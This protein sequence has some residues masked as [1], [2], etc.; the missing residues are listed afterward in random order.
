MGLTSSISL[1][2]LVVYV[3]Y[4][5]SMVWEMCSPHACRGVQCYRPL[6]SDERIDLRM[7]VAG[8]EVWQSL[9]LSA[10][11]QLD[12]QVE[13]PVPPEVRLGAVDNLTVEVFL[14]LHGATQPIVVARTNAVKRMLPRVHEA[15]MLLDDITAS[16][17]SSE[18]AGKKDVA[19]AAPD[20]QGKV[21]HYIFARSRMDVRLVR[22]RTPHASVY[23]KDGVPVGSGFDHAQRRFAPHFY[24]DSFPLLSK[25]ALPLSSDVQRKHPALRVRVTPIS[26]GWHRF[27]SQMNTVLGLLQVSGGG[28]V[29]LRRCT[30]LRWPAAGAPRLRPKTSD[31]RRGRHRHSGP[32]RGGPA[33]AGGQRGALRRRRLRRDP[34][35][36]LGGAH[37]PLPADAGD[38]AACRPPTPHAH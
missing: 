6:L 11:E 33:A 23:F 5:T 4:M 27:I 19:T 10:D 38:A 17:N 1:A 22:D 32:E 34:R 8:K 16:S 13:L 36:G 25:H 28:A 9:G 30:A 3:A 15:T 37:V 35:A 21:P 31:S 20:Y 29:E 14:A 12:F 26:S 24:V 18:A 2:L 7:L